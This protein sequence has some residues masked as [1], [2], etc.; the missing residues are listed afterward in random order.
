MGLISLK[1]VDEFEKSG[2]TRFK[3]P[4]F[5]A[6]T[7]SFGAIEHHV[8]SVDEFEENLI[9]AKLEKVRLTIIAVDVDYS[10]NQ[11]LLDDSYAITKTELVDRK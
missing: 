4:N 11:V 1:Q 9:E 8:K 3:N 5:V 10:R 7:K 6:L 2:Y